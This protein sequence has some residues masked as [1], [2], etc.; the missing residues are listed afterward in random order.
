[1]R[2]TFGLT[3]LGIIAIILLGGCKPK[4]PPTGPQKPLPTE[5]CPADELVAPSLNPVSTEECT[6]AG[7]VTSSTPTLSVY[8]VAM[9]APKPSPAGVCNPEKTHFYLS[10]GP[11]YMDEIGG[12]STALD[13]NVTVPL[14]PGKMYRWAAAGMSKSIEG[15]LSAYGY[16]I[17]GPACTESQM[18][19]VILLEPADGSII[20]TLEPTYKWENQDL[21]TPWMYRV[22]WSPKPVFKIWEYGGSFATGVDKYPPFNPVTS[23][24]QE[25]HNILEDCET[26]Y[27]LVASA[28]FETE[29]FSEV[30]SFTVQLPGSQ[31]LEIAQPIEASLPMDFLGIKNANCRSNPWIDGNEVGLLR[32]GE[33]ATLL[34]LNED[35]YWGFFE[36]MNGLKCWVHMSSVEMQPPE[37]KFDPSKYPVIAHDPPPDNAPPVKEQTQGCY[38]PNSSGD[39]VC[40]APC[41]NPSFASRTCTP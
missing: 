10:T 32:K 7:C 5:Q 20:D 35:A 1:M 23:L 30:W 28:I 22:E 11:D 15:P 36:L 12:I 16:F 31:C 39:L 13:W 27:W 19:P 8:Y 2:N 9:T 21:C 38:A 6:T 33:T 18:T 17:A 3:L 4:D 34:G 41:P 25:K 26:Y 24:K 14:Q 29:K 40:Q 37:S